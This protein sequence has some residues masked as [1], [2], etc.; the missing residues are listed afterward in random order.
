MKRALIALFGV[1][2]VLAACGGNTGATNPSTGGAKVPTPPAA[3]LTGAGATFPAFLCG[4]ILCLQQEV[5]PGYRQLPG[6]RLGGGYPAADEED[7]GLWCQRRA[8]QELRG[9]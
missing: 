5:Q 2:M 6:G 1:A 3:S 8:A 4:R 7:C 9:R